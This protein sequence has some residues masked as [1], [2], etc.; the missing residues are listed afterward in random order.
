[1]KKGKTQE[2]EKEKRR[3]EGRGEKAL[4][5]ALGYLDSV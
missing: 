5:S 1:M 2:A 3:R 4:S